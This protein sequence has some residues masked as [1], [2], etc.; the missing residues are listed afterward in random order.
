MRNNNLPS[1]IEEM[2]SLFNS[3]PFSIFNSFNSLLAEADTRM[4]ELMKDPNT[5]TYTSPDGSTVIC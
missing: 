1:L 2:D 4:Q 3:N 5:K